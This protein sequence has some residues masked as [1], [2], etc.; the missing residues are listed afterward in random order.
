MLPA[1]GLYGVLAYTMSQRTLELFR[2]LC[3][4]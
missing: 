2:P 1:L 4:C 3:Y